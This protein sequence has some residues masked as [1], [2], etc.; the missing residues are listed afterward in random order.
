MVKEFALLA[1][2]L[3]QTL[4]ACALALVVPN[5]GTLCVEQPPHNTDFNFLATGFTVM[6]FAFAMGFTVS[7][8]AMLTVSLSVADTG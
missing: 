3:A 6:S 5:T 8:G 2:M 7:L 1:A 4:V